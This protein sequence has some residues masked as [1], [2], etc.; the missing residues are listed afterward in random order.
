[1]VIILQT[2]LLLVNIL[3]AKKTF[4]LT[5]TDGF[6]TTD[7]QPSTIDRYFNTNAKVI[8]NM[9]AMSILPYVIL[10]PFGGP[11][12]LLAKLAVTVLLSATVMLTNPTE[13]EI[14]Q[15]KTSKSMQTFAK[16]ML[17]V[18]MSS[19]ILFTTKLD[20]YGPKVLFARDHKHA[21]LKCVGRFFSLQGIAANVTAGE[22]VRRALRFANPKIAR[23]EKICY[24]VSQVVIPHLILLSD[25]HVAIKIAAIAL[26]AASLAFEALM[27]YNTSTLFHK[28]EDDILC[29][30]F[31]AMAINYLSSVPLAMFYC[32]NLAPAINPMMIFPALYMFM[33]STIGVKWME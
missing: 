29:Y 21:P 15:I 32:S 18:N 14:A 9:I 5:Q 19:I 22:T 30:T 3:Q 8:I 10:I 11:V 17:F 24:V 6:K 28:S 25:L 31:A 33:V 20:T 27:L 16:V 1:M 12:P 23:I 4:K 2:L 13:D 7:D 26:S